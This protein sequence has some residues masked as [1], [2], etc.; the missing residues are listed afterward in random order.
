MGDAG[1]V[2]IG[3][4]RTGGGKVSEEV[5]GIGSWWAP[6][7]N[8][9]PAGPK[10]RRKSDKRVSHAVTPVVPV[11]WTRC[12]AWGRILGL[13]GTRNGFVDDILEMGGFGVMVVE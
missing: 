12:W 1:P 4:R 9:L 3:D 10:R 13:V 2:V 8:S 7:A 6:S 5:G 11:E